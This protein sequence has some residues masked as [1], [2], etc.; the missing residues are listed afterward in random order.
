M[1]GLSQSAARNTSTSGS[2][3]SSHRLTSPSVWYSPTNIT[4]D[5]SSALPH[6]RT[7]SSIVSARLVPSRVRHA[8]PG[9]ITIV[10][11]ASGSCGDD[12]VVG[13]PHDDDVARGRATTGAVERAGAPATRRRG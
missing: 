6:V 8:P 5:P 13:P 11:S 4:S 3:S 1:T 10:G 2:A 9:S 7:P 12:V